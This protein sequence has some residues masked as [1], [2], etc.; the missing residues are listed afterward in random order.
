MPFPKYKT[1]KK[2][3]LFWNY[4]VSKRDDWE[5]LGE[6]ESLGEYRNGKYIRFQDSCSRCKSTLFLGREETET[7]KFCP[8]CLVKIRD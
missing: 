2:R 8:R 3:I 5:D 7:F 6:I 1:T 4:N